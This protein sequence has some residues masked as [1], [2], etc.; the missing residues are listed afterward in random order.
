MTVF[1]GITSDLGTLFAGGAFGGGVMGQVAQS[2]AVGGA[3]S[4]VL[5]ALQSPAVI[6]KL[7]P[8]GLLGIVHPTTGAVSTTAVAAA[9]ATTVSALSGLNPTAKTMTISFYTANPTVAPLYLAQGWT[10]IPG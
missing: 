6:E 1:T 9:P 2:V 5:A 4:A 8:L 10:I 3:G 7:D